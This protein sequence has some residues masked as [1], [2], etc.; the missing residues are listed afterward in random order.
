[1]RMLLVRK[2]SHLTAAEV[3]MEEVAVPAD[4]KNAVPLDLAATIGTFVVL[5]EGDDS[6][7][8]SGT[9]QFTVVNDEKNT[10]RQDEAADCGTATARHTIV[11]REAIVVG[12]LRG[13]QLTSKRT[14]SCSRLSTTGR[15]LGLSCE[16]DVC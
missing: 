12:G 11:S 4:E 14:A 8:V 5:R 6:I 1:M 16:N 9:P 10:Y 15:D 2:G 13:Q 3:R 7:V